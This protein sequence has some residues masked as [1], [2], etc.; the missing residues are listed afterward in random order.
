MP[1]IVSGPTSFRYP[2]LLVIVIGLMTGYLP[3]KA[4]ENA[5]PEAATEDPTADKTALDQL[6]VVP[7]GTPEQLLEFIQNLA[8]SRPSFQSRDEMRQHMEQVAEAISTAADAVL[9]GSATDEQA[10]EALEWKMQ[11]FDVRRKLGDRAVAQEQKKFLDSLANDPR[12]PIAKAIARIRVQ[13]QLKRWRFLD[14]QEQADL[15]N[16]F[17]KQVE[18]DGATWQDV[19]IARN[20]GQIGEMGQ[21]KMAVKALNELLA[22]FRKS[23]DPDIRQMLPEL[24]ATARLVNL[25]GNK[26]ELEGTLLNGKPLDWESFRGKVVLVDFWATWCGPCR[27]EVPNI[28]KNY[29]AYHDQGFDVL[30]ISLD[31]TRE[32]AESY[33][34]QMSIPWP[35]VFSDKPGE[36]GWRAPLARKYAINAIPRAILVNKEGIVISMVARGPLLDHELEKIFGK[37]SAKQSSTKNPV[38]QTA[39]QVDRQ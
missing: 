3:A 26:I 38:T 31:D 6:F 4:D 8:V 32:A 14:P 1:A 25:M 24:E 36:T 35:T 28:L 29:R 10:V 11:A 7:E 23:R 37:P 18:Q 19:M 30:G 15:I 2:V 13:S 34:K 9:A 17:V 22:I 16:T 5:V 39:A 21:D 27:S 12:K 33:V 20:L